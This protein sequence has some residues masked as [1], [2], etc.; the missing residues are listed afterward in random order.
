[1]SLERHIMFPCKLDHLYVH[2]NISNDS[3]ILC[4]IYIACRCSFV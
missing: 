1:M 3:G 2:K 4:S